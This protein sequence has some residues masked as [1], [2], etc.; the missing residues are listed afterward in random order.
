MAMIRRKPNE[1]LFRES[2]MTFGEHLEELRTCLFRALLWLIGGFI[3]GLC[4]ARPVIDFIQEPLKSAMKEYYQDRETK[5][6]QR[7]EEQGEPLPGSPEQLEELILIQNLLPEEVYIDPAELFHETQRMFQKEPAEALAWLDGMGQPLKDLERSAG[8]PQKKLT[9]DDRARMAKELELLVPV[10][11]RALR[12][13]QLDRIAEAARQ[14]AKA[15]KKQESLSKDELARLAEAIRA[16]ELEKKRLEEQLAGMAEAVDLLER[17][18]LPAKG[19]HLE[20]EDLARIFIWRPIEHDPRM[21]T[22]AFNAPEPFMIYIKA[23][24]LAGVLIASPGIFYNIW[25]F[26]AAGLYHHERRFV[27]VFGPFSLILFFSGVALV[28]FFVFRIV[29]R[30]LFTFNEWLGIGIQPRITEWLGFALILP[31]G[32]GIAFQLPLVMLFLERI[33]VFTVR[34]Y[35]SRWRIAI[36]VIFVLSMFLTPA[37]PGSM[38]LMAIPLTVLYFGGVLLCRYMPRRRSPYDET[39]D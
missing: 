16:V 10:E 39:Q 29:L 36:L 18:E 25:S 37:D 35:L 17:A 24:L 38:M 7:L 11:P 21:E 23:A 27:Y 20:R 31:L 5:K 32:F 15:V 4:V 6:F 12:K 28:F 26:V 13:D 33:G 19:P 8:N 9:K 34:A 22:K 30:F 1:D 14:T 3:A 2:T